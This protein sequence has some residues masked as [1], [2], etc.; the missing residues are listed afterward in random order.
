MNK[1]F[2]KYWGKFE[3]PA[4]EDIDI[5]DDLFVCNRQVVVSP[6]PAR[7]EDSIPNWDMGSRETVIPEL[8]EAES[9]RPP[10]GEG[11]NFD[12]EFQ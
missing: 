2:T 8:E 5:S 9:S 7:Q 1:D 12:V 3:I 11:D 6:S 10:S 4:G